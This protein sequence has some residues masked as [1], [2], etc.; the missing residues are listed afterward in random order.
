LWAISSFAAKA[1][2]ATET[3]N[4]PANAAESARRPVDR[5]ATASG[6]GVTAFLRG[7]S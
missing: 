1:V 4:A 7:E 3:V 2:I 5:S 6:E